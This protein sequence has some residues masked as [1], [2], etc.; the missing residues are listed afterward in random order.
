MKIYGKV[1]Y[2]K[3]RDRIREKSKQYYRMHPEKRQ[4]ITARRR[5]RLANAE[6]S[7]TPQEWREVK[8]RYNFTCLACHR[9]EPQIKLTPDHVVPLAK[10]GN[11]YITNIQPLCR[12]CNSAK[13]DKTIDYRPAWEAEHGGE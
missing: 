11:N 12:S 8:E 5:T 7:F 3:N 10:H 4:A 9:Q 13:R 6:G 1:N 2:E